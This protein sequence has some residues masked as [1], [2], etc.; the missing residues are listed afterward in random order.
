MGQKVHPKGF[1]L[2]IIHTWD[3]R[4]YAEKDYTDNLHEDLEIRR[5]ILTW[6]FR[7]ERKAS[8]MKGVQKQI[9]DNRRFSGVSQIE[10][11]RKTKNITVF[12]STARPGIVI[13][14][15]GETIETLTR[16]LRSLTGKNVEIK[17]RPID[18]PDLDA[19]LVSE[20]I[21]HMLER[22]FGVRRAIRQS[23]ERVMRAGAKG[24]KVCVSG[25]LGGS[26][27][28]RSEWTRRGRV[29]LH[30]LR[31]NIDYAATEAFTT[32]GKIGIKVWIYKGDV[33]TDRRAQV[34]EQFG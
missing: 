15:S 31:A 6:N 7:G 16:H 1:R 3:S 10:I 5:V 34:I 22:R 12:V 28:A 23:A 19:F 25:R 32:Y 2:G 14:R 27:I 21:A 18:N 4:W 11:E 9:R 8:G 29:P 20:S 24:T 30:T 17:I 33:S 13:G 26:E